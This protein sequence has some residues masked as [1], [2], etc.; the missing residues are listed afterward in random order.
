MKLLLDKG[1]QMDFKDLFSDYDLDDEGMTLFPL[2]WAAK[3]G[4]V[5]IVRLLHERGD[6]VNAKDVSGDDAMSLAAK[7]GH[8]AVVSL[9]LTL[10]EVDAD[11]KDNYGRTPLSYAA[12]NEHGPVV[13]VL[14]ASGKVDADSSDQIGR[15]P[16]SYVSGS[17]NVFGEAVV[18]LL[19]AADHVNVDS[20]DDT[21][22]T[23]LS[24]A[25]EKAN[26]PAMELLVGSGKADVNSSD[27]SGRTPLS[28]LDP[29]PFSTSRFL[30]AE[31]IL[32]QGTVS[33]AHHFPKLQ[34]TGTSM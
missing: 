26:I 30:Q 34:A 16:L 19:V 33:A 9:L 21:G 15:T 10:D 8:E 6:D 27:K 22:R 23:P 13:A 2:L 3:Y 5:S 1:A 31:S 12:Q 17:G 7:K 11:R 14:L 28:Y 25:A 32:I 18:K 20:K 4:F 29:A 24:Y